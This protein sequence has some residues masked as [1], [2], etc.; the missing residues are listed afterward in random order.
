[1]VYA[2]VRL[3]GTVNIKPNI[4]KTM[5]LL[6]LT[7][8]NH[9][10]LIEENDVNKGMLQQRMTTAAWNLGCHEVYLKHYLNNLLIYLANFVTKP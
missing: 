2:V 10:V 7:R 4:K 9:C 3:R 8:A 5:Q 6:N 1:M